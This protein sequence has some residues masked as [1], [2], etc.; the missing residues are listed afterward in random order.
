MNKIDEL[1]NKYGRVS[2]ESKREY[3]DWLN[4]QEMFSGGELAYRYID[5]EWNVYQSV[6]LRAPEKRENE[7]FHQ[8]L[9]HPVTKKPCAVPP[10]GFSRTPE[11]LQEMISKNLILFGSDESTQPRQKMILK[12]DKK[13]QP[14]FRFQY[15]GIR[16]Y[17][18]RTVQGIGHYCLS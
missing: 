8:P 6:S 12:R 10:N 2:E 1:K 9:I 15:A 16:C 4:G 14:Y 11:T 3:V 18:V 7:K 17:T 5:D 13:Q